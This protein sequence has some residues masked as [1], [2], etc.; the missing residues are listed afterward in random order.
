MVLE[1]TPVEEDD[2]DEA[3]GGKGTVLL[4]QQ[5]PVD[6]YSRPPVLFGIVSQPAADLA[7]AVEAITSVEQVLDV[8][9]HDL[10]DVA[11]LVVELVEVLGGAGVGVRGA[12][13]G[14]EVVKLHEGVRPQARVVQ[15]RGR[16]RRR[17]LARQVGKVREGQLA[18]E[19]PLADA[20][21]HNVLLQCVVD[22]VRA[23]LDARLRFRVARQLAQHLA[24][25]LLDFA[26]SGLYINTVSCD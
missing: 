17:E 22:R 15:L 26:E 4:E 23:R 19:R 6:P 10:C 21:E 5:L 24:H 9:G 7:H 1:E 16:V 12:R 13:L 3:N 8:L 11:Q 2:N 25:L 14:D 20:Q 18:R